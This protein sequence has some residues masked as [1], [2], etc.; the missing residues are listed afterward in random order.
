M[1]TA[2]RIDRRWLQALWILAL[3][4]LVAGLAAP[5]LTAQALPL[6]DGFAANQAPYLYAAAD[7]GID[8]LEVTFA[9]DIVPILQRSCQ[10]CHSPGGGGP[11]SLITYEEV[12][13]WAPLIK[14]RTAIRD[15]IGAMPPWYIEKNIGVQHF[16]DDPSLSDE[17]LA[18]IQAWV[19]NGTPEGDVADMPPPREFGVAGVWTLGEP[20]LILRSPDM[21][22]PAVASDRWGFIGLVPTGLTQDRYVASVEIREFNDVPPGTASE[23]VGGLYLWHHMTYGVGVLNEEGTGLVDGTRQRYPIHEIGRNADVMNSEAGLLMPANSALDLGQGH[24]HANGRE[25]TAHLEFGFKFFPVGYEPTYARGRGVGPSNSIDVNS[26]PGLGGQEFHT[27]T[28]LQQHTKMVAYEPHMHAPG[29]RQCLEAIWG[30]SVFTINCTG[31]DHSW[32]RQYVYDEDYAPLLP[33]GTIIHLAGWLDM[34]TANVN[35]VVD[36][37]NWA[38]SGR[39]SVAN[40]FSDLGQSVQLT[41]EQFQ[42]E[43]AKRREMMKDRNEF[44]VG[45]PLCWVSEVVDVEKMMMAAAEA[46]E[47]TQ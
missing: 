28:V 39:R 46:Q 9:K 45:C 15:R 42:A 21:T 26:E 22:M 18:K 34:S 5:E 27:Y 19:D 3:I 20:D 1:R 40:M 47:G 8:P 24:L 41:E 37:R 36:I 30:S 44:D 7:F 32:V 43:M 38:G 29:V 31:Y 12:R 25:T 11:Q 6:R 4:P 33:K 13:A 17:D 10:D 35:N 23:T 2:D 14:Y 16:K